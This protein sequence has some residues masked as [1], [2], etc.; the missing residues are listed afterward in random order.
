L[1]PTVAT[2]D[3]IP[4]HAQQLMQ[5]TLLQRKS[6]LLLVGSP[7]AD[8]HRA[9]DLVNACLALT[10]HAGPAA[11]IMPRHRST[12]Q[13]DWQVPDGVKDLPF[14]PSIQSAY[15]QGYRRMVIAP[16]YTSAEVL[17]D[18]A[19]DVLFIAGAYAFDA[20]G[21]YTGALSN[22]LIRHD[23]D[24]FDQVIVLLAVTRLPVHGETFVFTDLFINDGDLP[25]DAHTSF[26]AL[27]DAVSRHRRQKVEIQLRAAIGQGLI[28]REDLEE[29]PRNRLIKQLL[30]TLGQ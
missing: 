17:R 5:P 23:V 15:A 13:K 6:G 24:L 30:A 26:D 14:L 10:E 11:R 29:L 22:A 9:I 27:T 16:G 19:K 18:Y 8:E 3:A 12:P 25:Y 2:A 1:A 28:R 20:I 4:E 7:A 21:T